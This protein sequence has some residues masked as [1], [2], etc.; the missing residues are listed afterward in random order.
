MARGAG[1]G[2]DAE[3]GAP[4][5]E[6]IEVAADAGARTGSIVLSRPSKLNAMSPTMLAELVTAAAWFDS[7]TDAV[8]VVVRG[9]G[10]A[11][12]AGFDLGSFGEQR[13]P[14]DARDTADLGRRMADAIT[15][16]RAVTL[17]AVH[18]HCV[19]GGLVLAA[20]CDLRVAEAGAMFSIPEVDLGI[21]L[22]W[23]GIPRLVREIGPAATKDL[24]M[25]CRRFDA[26]EAARLGL[27]T[28][29]VDVGTAHAT[30]DAIAT[31]LA[32][33]SP[34][35]LSMTKRHVNAIA[36]QSGSTSLSFLD[37][38]ALGAAQRDPASRAAARDY[39]DRRR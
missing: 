22:A 18:G 7:S 4:S 15:G 23:G 12:C 19:G 1:A 26:D 8:A 16:M 21:P 24:V 33:K 35:V 11:F 6:T 31:D 34:L 38:D 14:G 37:A 17:A 3:A 2:A 29:V 20:S 39:L 5:F 28:R 25:T 10:R 27:I 32:R 13:G 36:E 9:S 30:A